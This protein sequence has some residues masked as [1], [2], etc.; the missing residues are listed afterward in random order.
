MKIC[1]ANQSHFFTI[2]SNLLLSKK[3]VHAELVKSED[4][5]SICKQMRK[6]VKNPHSYER[7]FFGRG[8]KTRTL[9]MQFWRLPFYRLNYTPIFGTFLL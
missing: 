5:N 3:S 7:G 2:H 4:V 8:A 6:K 9:D 1:E